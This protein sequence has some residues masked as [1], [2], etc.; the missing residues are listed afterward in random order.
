MEGSQ[1]LLN[2]S[3]YDS[4]KPDGKSAARGDKAV[5]DRI[6]RQ[7]GACARGESDES[8]SLIASYWCLDMLC[9]DTSNGRTVGPL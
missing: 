3:D 4:L 5:S 1:L 8:V 2:E 7:H 6:G 9:S